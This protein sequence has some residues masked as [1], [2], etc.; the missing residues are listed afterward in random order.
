MTPAGQSVWADVEIDWNQPNCAVAS[1][2]V[3]RN[4][5]G[6]WTSLGVGATQPMIT[7]SLTR[8]NSEL[9]N[10]NHCYRMIVDRGGLV[11]ESNN[12]NNGATPWRAFTISNLP[13]GSDGED[14][15]GDGQIDFPAD[16]DCSSDDDTDETPGANPPPVVNA[17]T[18]QSAVVGATINPSGQSATD[19]NA[20]LSLSWTF[21]S[22]PGPTPTI[23]NPTFLNPSFGGF[24]APGVYTFQLAATDGLGATTVDTMIVTV[25]AVGQPDLVSIGSSFVVPPTATVGTPFNISASVQNTGTAVALPF[26]NNL[27]YSWTSATGPFTGP[28]TGGTI[29]TFPHGALPPGATANDP[30]TPFTPTQAGTVYIQHCVDSTNANINEIN[31]TPN[32]QVASVVVTVAAAGHTVTIDPPT[33]GGSITITNPPGGPTCTAS[34]AS[35]SV[36]VPAGSTP[37]VTVTPFLEEVSSKSSLVAVVLAVDRQLTSYL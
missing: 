37:T 6:P 4:A 13:Q 26:S 9:K 14:N 30:S 29:A 5:G 32:C 25:T 2:E 31:E 24:T 21:V 18:D 12:G 15:D 35:C 33:G 10:G 28:P 11:T 22:G 20:P 3:T 23:T 7:P 34:A 36:T 8:A 19:P 27:T 17:G 1:P 16:T